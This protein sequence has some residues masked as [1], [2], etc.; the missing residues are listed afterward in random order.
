MLIKLKFK[1][2]SILAKMNKNKVAELDEIVIELLRVFDGLG[3][4]EVT[5]VINVLYDSGEILEGFSRSVFVALPKKLGAKECEI[6]LSI[7]SMSYILIRILIIRA[8]SKNTIN[9]D[10]K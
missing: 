10:Y 8:H 4:D 1:V 2:R 3:L 6:H 7:S 9:K 5:E